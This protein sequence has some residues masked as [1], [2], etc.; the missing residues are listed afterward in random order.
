[1]KKYFGTD[2]IRGIPEESL[3]EIIVKK[4]CSSVEKI[5]EPASIALILDTRQSCDQIT[6]WIVKGF[7]ENITI[8]NYGILPSGS[9]PVLLEAF[10]EDLGIIISA[11]HNPSEYNGIKLIDKSGSKLDDNIEIQIEKEVE[12]IQLPEKF[13]KINNS[14]KGYEVYLEYLKSVNNLKFDKFDLMIDAANGSAYKIVEDLFTQKNAK[15][16]LISN[17]PDGKNINQNCGTTFPENLQRNISKGQI[18]ISF[19]GDADR[20]I[21]IDEKKEVVNGDLL[22]TILSKY[23]SEKGNLTGDIVVST[24]MS[25]YGFKAAMSDFGFKLIETPVGD[26][27]VAEAMNKNN[28]KLGGEQSGHIILKDYLPVGDALVTCLL[29]LEA[30]DYFDISLVD[31]R[32]K[33]LDEYPQKLTNIELDKPIND[34]ELEFINQIALDMSIKL[35]LDGRYL[36]RNSGTEPLLRVLVEAKTQE[37]MESFSNELLSKINNYLS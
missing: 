30:I 25:N 8:T 37:S 24:V 20:L 34:E 3:K 4:I 6:D 10:N 31:F 19:D 35:D 29:V 7:S 1:L 33:F 23:L 13:S 5:L 28:A 14:I 16:N 26:K 2:G 22:L 12:N 11:S 21:M 36:I 18:G 9:M 17:N 15:F 32:E 27:Y